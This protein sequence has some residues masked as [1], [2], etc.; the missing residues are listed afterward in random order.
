MIILK[1]TSVNK[2]HSHLYTKDFLDI[3]PPHTLLPHTLL[4]HTLLLPQ[5]LILVLSLLFLLYF[6]TTFSYFHKYV[7]AQFKQ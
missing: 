1:N 2:S 7:P 5:G 6:D 4:P 3:L